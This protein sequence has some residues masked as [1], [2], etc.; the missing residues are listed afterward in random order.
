MG[1]ELWNFDFEVLM[2]FNHNKNNDMNNNNNADNLNNNVKDSDDNAAMDSRTTS[3]LL[4]CIYAGRQNVRPLTELCRRPALQLIARFISL[5]DIDS[6]S[7]SHEV[8]QILTFSKLDAS[9]VRTR[10]HWR[11]GKSWGDESRLDETKSVSPFKEG[12]MQR[13]DKRRSSGRQLPIITNSSSGVKKSLVR[14]S[15]PSRLN[16]RSSPD[17]PN[18]DQ[19]HESDAKAT[20]RLSRTSPKLGISSSLASSRPKPKP[21]RKLPP[22]FTESILALGT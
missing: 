8:K 12:G 17:L 11:S 20:Q 7:F 15:A 5:D 14:L 22:R 2:N 10:T 13:T 9:S 18:L 19:A 4:H 1:C 16:T 21:M 6:L 3:Y